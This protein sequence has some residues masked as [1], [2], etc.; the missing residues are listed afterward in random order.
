M[1]LLDKLQS[2]CYEMKSSD[3][4]KPISSNR[5][6]GALIIE[7]VAKCQGARN[8]CAAKASYL[9]VYLETAG[10]RLAIFM[11]GVLKPMKQSIDN[12]LSS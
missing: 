4:W 10:C 12:T 5:V 9:E 6:K 2:G 11:Y 8:I 1:L 7:I 3:I